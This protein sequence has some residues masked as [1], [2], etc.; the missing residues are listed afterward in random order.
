M[1][2]VVAQS[3]HSVIPYCCCWPSVV[4]TSL[5]AST[6]G[7]WFSRAGECKSL[8]SSSDL[9]SVN[10]TIPYNFL[11][12]LFFHVVFVFLWLSCLPVCIC[13]IPVLESFLCWLFSFSFLIFF[14]QCYTI[15]PPQPITDSCVC[16][17]QP[18]TV[19]C[20]VRPVKFRVGSNGISKVM[21]LYV[22]LAWNPGRVEGF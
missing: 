4:V 7:T 18:T 15:I 17:F 16:Y 8:A 5:S 2:C 11:L 6:V 19:S 22:S 12:F 3:L 1:S 20:V 9:P 14:Q 13:F 10:A 21:H